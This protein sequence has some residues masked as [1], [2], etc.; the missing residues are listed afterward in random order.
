MKKNKH[1]GGRRTAMLGVLLGVMYVALTN[2]A[3]A[4]LAV[5]KTGND[6]NACTTE[7]RP[8]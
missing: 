4:Q 1:G 2:S 8:A 5:A 3:Q 7:Q 6:D